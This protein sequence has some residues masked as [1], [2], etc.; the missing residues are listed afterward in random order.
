MRHFI[1]HRANPA[2]LAL[3][4][5]LALFSVARAQEEGGGFSTSGL[6][7]GSVARCVNG[8]ETPAR[9]VSIGVEGGSS[10]IARTNDDGGF[11]ISLPAGT[12]TVT[13]TSA[14]G[15]ASRPYVPVEQGETL[16]IGILDIG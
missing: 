10:Q 3:A 7:Q 16:D 6:I 15:F 2:L 13:A 11:F 8:V 5:G 12:Y 14:D 4:V 1:N 9:G